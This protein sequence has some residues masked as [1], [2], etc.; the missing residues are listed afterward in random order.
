MTTDLREAPP[1]AAPRLTPAVAGL[2]GVLSLAAAVGA[3]HLVAA[4]VGSNASPFLAVG[5]AAIDLTPTWLKN[6]AVDAFGTGD[7]PVLLAGMAV[8]LLLVAVGAGL[9]S[10]TRALPGQVVVVVFGAVGVAAV[11]TRPDVGQLAL[12]APL[13]SLVAGVLVFR[14]LHGAALSRGM[15][16][17][18]REFLVTAVA[19]GVAG[20]VGQWLGSRK[21]AE[22]SRAAVGP[23]TAAEPAP[24]VPAGADFA[25]LG[26][27]S[28]ITSNSD[29]YRIDTAL[30]LPQVPAED[31]T[32]RIHGMVDRE[33]TFSYADIRNRPLVERIVTLC[34]VSNPVG[35]P[36]ISTAR[37]LGVDLAELL[38]E[39]GVRD[40]AEQLFSTS[41]DGFTA[42]TPVSTIL[43][44]GRGAM[45]A[46]GMNGEPLPIAHGFPARLV[47]PGLYGYV[48]ATKWVTD[49]EL[50]TWDAKQAYWL[51]RGWSE[52]GPI[53]TESRIDATRS[54]AGKVR[55]A[56]IAW[57]Q[58]TGIDKVEVRLDGGAWQQAVLSTE[59]TTDAWRMWW[60]ELD[61][62][63]GSHTAT[64]RA[65]DRSG[66]TQTDRIADVVPDGA[67]GWHTLTFTA[68]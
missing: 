49:L 42:G 14:W 53:K 19:A 24:P 37:F 38:R 44:P 26:T 56:G 54:A 33:L 55:V 28:F 21:D 22:G 60:A 16:G 62:T 6:F 31:W 20:A 66:Y 23:L 64:V 4:F 68:Q 35:G 7:K 40:G 5:N 17:S 12:A 8:V 51:Q 58:H 47:V 29:F 50:T 27:P 43:E 25:K 41:S 1:V 59:V 39:A 11:Y 57:A 30:V 34:C 18:R 61:A 67:T 48:S 63:P 2:T 9:L 13:A 10:R 65:T 45:L 46:I 15:S 52:Q 32:L 36:Y 3:G